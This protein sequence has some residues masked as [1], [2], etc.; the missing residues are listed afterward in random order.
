MEGPVRLNYITTAAFPTAKAS[1]VQVM[2]MCAA[3][4]EAGAL[5][6]LVSRWGKVEK[7]DLFEFYGLAQTFKIE[8]RPWPR[9][10]RPADLFQMQAVLAERGPDW[11][12]YSRGRDLTAPVVAILRGL[13]VAVEVHGLPAT[14]RERVMLQWMAARPR[15]R[16]ITISQPLREHYQRQLGIS[17]FLAPDAVDVRRFTPMLTSDEARARLRL[18]PGPWVVYVGG[19]YAGR[20]LETLFAATADLPVKLLIV[21]GRDEADVAAWKDKATANAARVRFEGYQPP[22]RIPLYLFAADILA[23]PYSSRIY[24][25]SGEDITNWTSPLKLYEYLAAGRP[26]VSTDVQ[27][28]RGVLEDGANA[29]LAEPDDVS[30]LR[31]SIRR[32]L[33]APELAARLAANARKKAQNHTWLARARAILELMSFD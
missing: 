23:M 30:S 16:L 28:V 2:Q 6:K 29:L 17:T 11:I 15:T 13:R 4:A 27:A 5:V 33:D 1:S 32:L 9:W 14:T 21:G 19:L 7:H 22:A 26:I 12:C 24:T 10:P 20:G 25:G 3:F 8:T 18:E 31:G